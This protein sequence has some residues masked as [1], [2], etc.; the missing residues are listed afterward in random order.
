MI[1]Q[2]QSDPSAR[3]ETRSTS[4]LTADSTSRQETPLAARSASRWG[5][6]FLDRLDRMVLLRKTISTSPV[7]NRLLEHSIYSTYLDCRAWGRE[8]QAQTIL[9]RVGAPAR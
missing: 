5:E 9:R 6:F 4:T 2:E 7:T 3:A 1:S 8:E